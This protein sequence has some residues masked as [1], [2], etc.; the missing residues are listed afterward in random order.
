MKIIR[1]QQGSP[2]WNAHRAKTRNASDATAMLDQ[3]PY[4]TRSKLVEEIATGMFEEVTDQKQA[5]YNRGHQAEFAARPNAEKRIEQELFP[6][7]ATDDNGYLGASFD[8][9]VDDGSVVWENKLYNEKLA[10]YIDEKNDLPP[11]HWPQAEQQLMVS[12][13]SEYYFTLSK[14]DGEII[15]DL[16]YQSRDERKAKIIAGWKQFD[17]DVKNYKATKYHQTEAAP[18]KTLPAIVYKLDGLIVTSNL[19]A[20]KQ[21]AEMLVEESKLP[22]ENDQ[23][24]ANREALNKSFKEAEEKIKLVKEQVVGEIKDVDTFCRDLTH[25]SDLL[26]QARLNGEKQVD[27]RKLELRQ[28]I[29]NAARIVYQQHIDTLNTRLQVVKMPT[30]QV[31]FVTPMKGKKTL[32]SCQDAIDTAL[33]NAKIDANAVADL[34]SINLSTIEKLGAT[35][36][37]LF[38]DRQQLCIKN[39]DDLVN[40]INV[41]IQNYKAEEQKKVDAAIKSSQETQN[42]ATEAPASQQAAPVSL[43]QQPVVENKTAMHIVQN[44]TPTDNQ[45]ILVI[46]DHWQVSEATATEWILSMPMVQASRKRLN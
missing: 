45:I 37:F 5:L 4:K 11:S 27:A 38:A 20:Y 25:I 24:F 15:A 41:R 40:V 36:E 31:D 16:W 3:S 39:T 26:R 19:D 10:I 43:R 28:K 14:E 30:L 17:E 1:V 33:A 22:M 6:C 21:A 42:L 2:E 44:K 18:V 13:A 35:Y 9:L 29:Q 46:A 12:G 8:G 34:M 7:V 32:Q 23:D